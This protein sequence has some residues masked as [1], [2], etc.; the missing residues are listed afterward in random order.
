MHALLANAGIPML[1]WQLPVAAMMLLPVTLI[2][3]IVAIPILRQP[4]GSVCVRVLAANLFSTFV[5]VPIA[6]GGMF[7]VDIVTTGSAA[8]GFDTPWDAFQSVVLQS[9][10]LPPYQEHLVWLVPAA[11]FVLLVPYFLVSVYT[12][13]WLLRRQFQNVDSHLVSRATW[14]ANAVS[15][16]ALA[17]CTVYWLLRAVA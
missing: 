7:I 10:W 6:W 3:S 8:P 15:Y 17:V 1:F 4:A 13:R 12:E 16:G 14:I 5:G 11:T 9:P 2:E